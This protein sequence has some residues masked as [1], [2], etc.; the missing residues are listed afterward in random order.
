MERK[1][2]RRVC[3]VFFVVFPGYRRCVGNVLYFW[4]N[5]VIIPVLMYYRMKIYFFNQVI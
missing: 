4:K 3:G 1:K 5:C 2:R